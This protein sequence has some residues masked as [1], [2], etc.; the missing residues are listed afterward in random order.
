MSRVK[1]C[2]IVNCAENDSK[3]RQNQSKIWNK[4]ACTT[5]RKD[6][7]AKHKASIK[8]REALEQECACQVVKVRGGIKEAMQG[9]W[10][11]REM[12]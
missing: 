3:N 10:H 2:I 1:G 12:L 7:L 11:F 6:A 8:H 9:R 5:L 4:E